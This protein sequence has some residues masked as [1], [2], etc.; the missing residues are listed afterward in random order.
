MSD[1]NGVQSHEMK[2]VFIIVFYK[3]CFNYVDM[4]KPAHKNT[5]QTLI[6]TP[7]T[8]LLFL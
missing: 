4:R 3:M 2:T 7:F 6:K 8:N 1:Q 5:A